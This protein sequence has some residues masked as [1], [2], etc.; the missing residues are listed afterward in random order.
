MAQEINKIALTRIPK[1]GGVLVRRLVSYCGGVDEV[2]QASKKELM[3]VPGVGASLAK[4]ILEK[5]YFEEA[6]TELMF[7][8][9]H[10]IKILFY[11][12][13]SYPKRLTHFHDAPLLLYFKG[14]GDLNPERTVGIIGTRKPTEHGKIICESIIEGLQEYNVSIISGLA[15][16]IDVC[17]HRKSLD[18]GIPT[19]GC[20]GHGLQK[21]YPARHKQT[22]LKMTENGGLLTEFT[23]KEEPDAPHFPMRNRVIAGLSDALVVVESGSSGGSMITAEIANRYNKDVFA[24]PGRLND[25]VSQ[26]CNKLIKTHKAQLIESAADIGYIMGWDK[27][28][29]KSPVQ[30]SL[31][32]DVNDEEKLIVLALE[33]EG[34]M[35]VDDLSHKT[36]FM[37]SKLAGVLLNLEFK[38]VLRSLPGKRYTLL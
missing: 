30:R 21:I 18:T 6:E 33:S 29:T 14:Q 22:A 12:D 13:K 16:G 11:T 19:F 28:G 31:F 3:T 1:A 23:S 2:F 17:S 26:G 38:G 10:D 4:T 27:D 37:Q 35:G 34:S 20:L 8:E 9:K 36:G 7:T 32:H 25:P 24:V 15:Y 5:S